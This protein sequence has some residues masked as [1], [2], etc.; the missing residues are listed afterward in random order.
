[1]LVSLRA[2]RFGREYIEDLSGELRIEAVCLQADAASL[3]YQFKITHE[4]DVLAEGRAA[5]VL[6][7]S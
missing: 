6:A 4:S 2:V 1:M 3:Q 7:N 5:V